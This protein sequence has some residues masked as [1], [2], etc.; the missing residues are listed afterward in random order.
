MAFVNTYTLGLPYVVISNC[1][2]V[3]GTTQSTMT[4]IKS[5]E[6][7]PGN[8]SA[9]DI[10][11]FEACLTKSGANSGYFHAVYWS[12]LNTLTGAQKVF[13]S[14]VN[15]TDDGATLRNTSYTYSNIYFRM[16]IV[17][18][19][20]S[21]KTLDPHRTYITATTSCQNDLTA[22]SATTPGS[23][24]ERV[25]T[26][27]GLNS[28]NWR[29]FISNGG[30]FIVAGGVQN[31]NDRLTCEWIKI[32]GLSSGTFSSNDVPIRGG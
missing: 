29:F 23:M 12:G 22:K 28:I 31:S 20:N 17:G 11:T 15:P 32:S 25:G 14:S 26:V 9:G 8:F 6:M 13:E 19:T 3:T 27:E 5:I 30:Y 21:T 7:P 2:A 10:V 1:Q 18:P 16:Q 4:A 24:W